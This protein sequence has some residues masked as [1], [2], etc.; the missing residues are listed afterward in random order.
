VFLDFFFFHS[1]HSES[2]AGE[3]SQILLSNVVCFFF[4]DS[5]LPLYYPTSQAFFFFFFVFSFSA[6][7]MSISSVGASG[8][9]RRE[10]VAVDGMIG[11]ISDSGAPVQ[12]NLTTDQ[13]ELLI[14]KLRGSKD[15]EEIAVLQTKLKKH[16]FARLQQQLTVLAADVLRQSPSLSLACNQCAVTR[17]LLE[18]PLTDAE[19]K[20]MSVS[21]IRNQF[22]S[23]SNNFQQNC[24]FLLPEEEHRTLTKR[25]IDL[26]R[27]QPV[28][29]GEIVKLQQQ[30]AALEYN[31]GALGGNLSLSGN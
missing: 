9:V 23:F 1:I 13:L 14:G 19:L 31:G 29:D 12:N 24:E 21:L 10:A 28:L 8:Q 2:S 15:P 27:I 20:D 3:G 5:F 11:S 18:R 7:G 16:N 25:L 22:G 17:D 30:Q 4:F 6:G 26:Q